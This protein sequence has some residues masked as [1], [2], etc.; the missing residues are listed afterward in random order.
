M[1]KGRAAVEVM[2][3]TRS[4][5][6]AAHAVARHPLRRDHEFLR[7]GLQRCLLKVDRF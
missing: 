6:P 5:G 1:K 7:H 4:Y 2:M 3:Q